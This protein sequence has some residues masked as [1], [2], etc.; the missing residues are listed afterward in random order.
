MTP[1]TRERAEE[2]LGLPAGATQRCT[3]RCNRATSAAESIA[4]LASYAK[5][6]AIGRSP[7]LLGASVAH[8]VS[9][10]APNPAGPMAKP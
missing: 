9:A 7:V 4:S 2:T 1:G 5:A 6:S 8:I 10:E 3:E